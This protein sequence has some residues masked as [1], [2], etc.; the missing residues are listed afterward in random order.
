MNDLPSLLHTAAQS[1]PPP[2]DLLA[3]VIRLEHRRARRQR[4]AAVSASV[5]A[6]AGIA[7]GAAWWAQPSTGP[8]Q[9]TGQPIAS[10]GRTSATISDPRVLT[11]HTWY[12]TSVTRKGRTWAP[13]AVSTLSFPTATTATTDDGA[14]TTAWSVTAR[15]GTLTAVQGVS[16]RVGEGRI[17]FQIGEALRGVLPGTTTW[18]AEAG[19]L[20]IRGSGGDVLRYTATRPDRVA[21]PGAI[22][23]RLVAKHG[24]GLLVRG[25]GPVPGTVTVTD[26]DGTQLWNPTVTTAGINLGGFAAGLYRVAATITNGICTPAT[27]TVTPNMTTQL[28]MACRDGL[29]SD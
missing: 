29:S 6:V 15:Y 5:L 17:A 12:L 3:G 26:A 25:S 18:T 23:V 22:R 4:A 16:T 24:A 9:A 27:V 14:N 2:G 21:P 11:R 28:Q 8:V 1:A 19:T 7:V 13:Q 10:P 20:T